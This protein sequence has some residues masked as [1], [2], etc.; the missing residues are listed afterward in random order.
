MVQ[1]LDYPVMFQN[2]YCVMV[3]VIVVDF[4]GEGNI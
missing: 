2:P 4:I 3:V 1:E